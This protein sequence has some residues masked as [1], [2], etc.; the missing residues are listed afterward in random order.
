MKKSCLWCITLLFQVFSLSSQ[1]TPI[2]VLGHGEVGADDCAN[3][4]IFC[5]LNG[6]IGNTAGY[7]AG[8]APGF[9]AAVDN[10]KWIG[11]L[12]DADSISIRVTPANCQ[13]GNGLEVA[14]YAVC[15]AP[16]LACSAGQVGEGT[17]VRT[18]EATLVPGQPYFLMIDGFQGDVCNFLIQ[19]SPT[20]AAALPPVDSAGT[21]QGPAIIAAGSANVYSVAPVSGATAYTWTAPP[22][23]QINGQASPVTLPASNGNHVTVT[24]GSQAGQV[25][26]TPSNPCRTGG[27]SCLIV[28]QGNIL[29]PPCPASSLPAAD[30]CEDICV[31]CNFNGYTGTTAGYT[32]QTPPGFCGT[33]ENEQWLGFV[34]GAPAATFTATPSNCTSGNGIQIAL[35]PSC[36]NIPIQCNAGAAGG[37]N[38]PVS[39]TTSLTPGVSYYLMID[40][41]AGDQCDFQITVAPPS[42]G[43]TPP[44]GPTGAI[45][46]PTK[47]CPGANIVFSVPPVSG[48]G[49][50]TWSAPPGWLVNG[51]PTP[52]TLAGAGGNIAWVTANAQAGPICVQPVN[53]CNTG[54]LACKNVTLQSIPLTQLPPA[55]VCA[56][57]LP[58]ELPWGD[59]CFT[60]GIYETTLISYQGCDSVVR[61][62]V[63]VKSP[64]IKFL[65]P[66]TVCTGDSVVVCGEAFT[67]EG[68]YTKICESYQGCDS[69]IN[70]S[71]INLEPLANIM[72]GA[73]SCV[74][75]PV[76]L[77]SAPSAGIKLWK[78][79][80]GQILGNGNTL[81]VNAPGRYI[82]EVNV[83][84]G[85]SICTGSDTVIVQFGTGIPAAGAS[86]GAILTCIQNTIPLDGSTDASDAIF[87]W[88]GPGGFTSALEDPFVGAP[89]QYVLT[90]THPQSGCSS[91]AT[92]E[93]QADLQAPDLYL[94]SGMVSCVTP[95]V[96]I[97][98]L[99]PVTGAL[100][101]WSGPGGF[102]SQEQHPLTGTPGIYTVTVTNPSN[103]CTATGE[104]T[105]PGTT[106]PPAV[107]AVGGTL[108]CATQ[109]VQLICTTDADTPA[110]SW[111]GPG[112][113][114]SIE[115]N[116]VVT[117]AGQY[118][119]TVTASNGCTASA[120][121]LVAENTKPPVIGITGDSLSCAQPH[122]TLA[123]ST[124]A[125]QPVFAW[126]GPGGFSSANQ[127]PVVT[128][129]GTYI[130][131]VT[132]A[133]TG[134]T[135][136]APVVVPAI[137]SLPAV[138]IAPA[139][140]L[141][142]IQKTVL[143]EG[144]TT[145][146]Q[147]V[148]SW[149]GPG[150]FSAFSAAV[151]VTIPGLYIL[152]VTDTLSGCTGATQVVVLENLNHPQAAV[153]GAGT[154]TCAMPALSLMG[155]S[156]AP[157]AEFQWLLPGLPPVDSPMLTVSLP[158]LYILTVTDPS[159]GCVSTASALVLQDTV[160][161]A[162]SLRVDTITCRSD[163]IF[164]GVANPQN[165]DFAWTGPNGFISDKSGFRI[166]VSELG[167]YT[168]TITDPGNGCVQILSIEDFIQ[169][170][171]PPVINTIS[172]VNDQFGQHIG[173]IN[174]QILY[175]GSVTVTWFKDSVLFSFAE[176]LTGLAA[177]TYTAVVTANDNGC[178]A[179][180]VA[181][182]INITVSTGSISEDASWEVF[183]NPANTRIHLRYLGFSQPVALVQLIDVTGRAVFLQTVLPTPVAEL[184]VTH[185]P[186]GVYRMQIQTKEASVW[187][188]VVIQR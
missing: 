130:V 47:V 160:S 162:T 20:D 93:V 106:L 150:G 183:P 144:S 33:I 6:Y 83:S 9:C 59:L 187:K 7:S 37:G 77:N 127:N 120:S 102:T 1:T 31:Y 126:G 168:V 133:S 110:F 3:A 185:L 58:Y 35:Y 158:G 4:C 122:V 62:F 89:G 154:I 151:N 66:Q 159:N 176:D 155:S 179:T 26:V 51:Q 104:I 76:T 87:L 22:G 10:D 118:E 111:Q 164:I 117:V 100:F 172:I 152:T 131:T 148:F 174:I 98:C 40:G 42:A 88:S 73:V 24:F 135:N 115:Q 140:K 81:T 105:V 82:L 68:N 46:G 125:D 116:P 157:G 169:N 45:S 107:A 96:Q 67:A 65:P 170:Q 180:L 72:P 178:S 123:C 43:L 124:P 48:A 53:S 91:Q 149:S 188:A 138:M 16:P 101:S 137:D 163:S 23:A 86:A 119:V 63:T 103:G 12:A 71:I 186:S 134:C 30:L 165:Y 18:L 139:G 113:F 145:A 175:P 153:S 146:M 8:Q 177:G 57:A 166:G 19:T 90:I 141:T 97:E 129:P 41:Y 36:G 50:Y 184:A 173:A 182:V 171:T 61:Q 78:D 142:C 181:E 147:P 143:L 108:T 2:C 54:D 156:T 79:E 52:V 84:A 49:A 28:A 132:D 94:T 99:S 56:E 136:S 74:L 75:P 128:T 112:G 32:G 55:V 39:V 60:S 17:V 13:L 27:S 21:V 109:T 92:V 161:P 95:L 167:V 114:I 70:F 29:P 34:A 11:F 15:D 64:I 85:G 38:M 80:N 69:T 44:I 25:C 121:A 5:S 14:L